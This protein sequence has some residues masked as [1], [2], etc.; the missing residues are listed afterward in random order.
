MAMEPRQTILIV[1][2]TAENLSM[3]G[4]LLRQD[5]TVRAANSGARALDLA[6]RQPRPDL[7]LLDVMMPGLS[8]F[9]VLARLQQSPLTCDIPVIFATALDSRHDEGRGLSL[10][11]VDYLTKPLHPPTLLARIRAQL[12][13]KQARDE[14]R[15]DNRRLGAEVVR[16]TQESQAAQDVMMRALAR[17]AETRD[18]ETGA[19]LLRTQEMVLELARRA[20]GHPRFSAELDPCSI[21]LIGKSAP[22]HD[23]GKVGVPDSIL[24]KP[25]RLTPEERAVMMA[26][27]R[28]GAEVI[29]RAVQD[30]DAPA[31]F[32]RFARQIALHHHERWDGTGYPDGLAG[33]EIPLAARLM[34]VADVFDALISRR[35]YKSAL[36]LDEVLQTMRRERGR[37]F[38]PDLLD[39]FL[40]GIDGFVGIAHRFPEQALAACAGPPS[41]PH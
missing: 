5:Y 12:K 37:H 1:D 10:G 24:L 35:V 4:E 7:I 18:N 11:A 17:L 22:L 6:G 19:H 40:D 8:G 16:R 3:L 9:D 25:G 27:A 26:H 20:S 36:A 41:A 15:Q 32:L 34:A 31:D 28:L 38:D 29:D 2:D 33:D 13:L 23:I 21:E 39:L 30:I 14:L